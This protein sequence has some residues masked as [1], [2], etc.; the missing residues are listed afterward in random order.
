ME[1]KRS[2]VSRLIRYF[3]GLFIM[4]LGIS[5]S[6]KSDL[7]VSPVSSLPYAASVCWG[8]EMGLATVLLHCILLI[9]Q[10]LMLRKKFRVKLLLQIPV[11]IVFGYF[12]T[13]SNNLVDQLPIPGGYVVRFLLL[14]MSIVLVAVGISFYL[15]SDIVPLAGEGFVQALS[16]TANI[17]FPSAKVVSDVAMVAIAIIAC[18]FVLRSFGSVGIGTILSALF[19]GAVLAWL[20]KL[21]EKISRKTP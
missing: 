7:G 17:P 4:T 13:F 9:L 16:D 21:Y 2:F 6:V 12:T 1:K 10:M 15:P 11:G 14:L 3:F 8:I 5:L 19:T 20:G 18:R